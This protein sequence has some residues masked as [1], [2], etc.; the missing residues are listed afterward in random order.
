MSSDHKNPPSPNELSR[1]NDDFKECLI[2]YDSV[3]SSDLLPACGDCPATM[4]ASCGRKCNAIHKYG[5]DAANAVRFLA[6]TSYDYDIMYAWCCKCH[7][8]RPLVERSCSRDDFK[9]FPEWVCMDCDILRK[10]ELEIAEIRWAADAITQAQLSGDYVK[11]LKAEEHQGRV[12]ESIE[13]GT[14]GIKPCPGCG[15]LTQRPFECGHLHC[16]V[17]GCGID[18]CYFC[19]QAYDKASIYQHMEE[20]HGDVF[21]GIIMDRDLVALAG[22]DTDSDPDFDSDSQDEEEDELGALDDDKVLKAR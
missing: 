3:Q 17:G 6:D 20:A 1:D 5:N 7:E 13:D 16:T 21:G 19:G 4:C 10:P 18:W 8:P 15:I 22:T 14:M 11:Q 12:F 2:C 9:L